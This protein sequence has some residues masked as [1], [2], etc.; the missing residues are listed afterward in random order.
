MIWLLIGYMF[1]CIYRPFEIWPILGEFRLELVYMLGAGTIWLAAPKRLP[2]NWLTLAVFAFAAALIVCSIL[3]G[4]SDNCLGGI[5][6]GLKFLVFFLMVV[7]VVHDENRLKQLIIGFL[8]VM[9]IYMLHSL[10]EFHCGRYVSRMG[11]SRMIGVD[12]TSDPNSFAMSIVL[13]L[14][15]VPALWK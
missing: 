1:M 13:S 11:I 4:W 8:A 10:W 14:V 7:T 9:A 12:H 5:E 2:L 3:S 6:P 15:F